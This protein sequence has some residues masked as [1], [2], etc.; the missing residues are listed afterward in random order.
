MHE[1]HIH[2]LGQINTCM[3][4]SCLSICLNTILYPHPAYCNYWS[5]SVVQNRPLSL[6][7][8]YVSFCRVCLSITLLL[9][10]IFFLIQHQDG[11]CYYN[12]KA[13]TATKSLLF[14]NIPDPLTISLLPKYNYNFTIIAY[15]MYGNSTTTMALSEHS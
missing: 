14:L 7:T 6:I 10:C 15:N 8:Y 4:C 12:V 11:V 5:L 1:L 9:L 13:Q 3:T 2:K